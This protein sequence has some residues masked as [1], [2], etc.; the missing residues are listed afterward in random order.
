MRKIAVV[1][2][3]Y[4]GS[5]DTVD[6]IASLLK[7]DTSGITLSII[8]V[9]NASREEEKQVLENAIQ[10]LKEKSAQ[11]KTILS[12]IKNDKNL[13]FSGGNNVG[14]KKALAER[15]DA[16]MILNNDTVVDK[17]IFQVLVK[18]LFEKEEIGVVVP[19]IYFYP[20]DEYHKDRY[21]KKDRGKVIWYMGGK[22]DWKNLIGYHK[23]VDEVDTGQFESVEETEY[24]TGA[25]LLVKSKVLEAV[26]LFD[27]KY[28]LYYE[29]ADLS[30]RIKQKK[31]TIVVDSEAKVWHKNAKSSGGSGSGLQDYYIS[32]NRMIFG[33]RYAPLKTKMM[34]LKE[35]FALLRKGRKWQRKG[36]ADFY[37]RK[38]G[39]GDY[40]FA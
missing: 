25:C 36:I 29:D 34:L 16:V 2:L 20:G 22:I 15:A 6:C 39:R 1:L 3:N 37:L 18:R 14:I 40:T 28:F 11:V 38:W 31:Y 17:D 10:K 13:G 7:T 24:A 21:S 27:D 35:S 33:M 12:L 23:G 9:D 30:F 32:R 26:G 19:K 8:V 4:N 5:A